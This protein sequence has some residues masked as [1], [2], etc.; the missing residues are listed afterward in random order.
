MRNELTHSF[1]TAERHEY[2]GRFVVFTGIDGAGKSTVTSMVAERL[3]QKTP[4]I[5]E[6]T[7]RR[8]RFSEPYVQEQ[9]DRL[10]AAIWDPTQ[11]QHLLGHRHYHFLLGAWLDTIDRRIVI[12]ALEQGKLVISDGWYHKQ[13]ARLFSRREFITPCQ[14][15][16]FWHSLTRPDRTYLLDLPP[17]IAAARKGEL[18]PN[19]SGQHDGTPDGGVSGFIEFQSKVR[20]EL[21]SM[22]AGD[23]GAVTIATDRR[24][25]EEVRDLVLE[26]IPGDW[27]GR[28]AATA[29]R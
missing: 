9:A 7:Y 2:P 3:R 4:D 21:R 12:P 14:E 5:V 13:V 16:G 26:N 27:L 1:T 20:Q 25:R 10:D 29:D 11:P 6:I 8:P 22:L 19:E 18:S 23:E 24:S 17:E 28:M 15:V